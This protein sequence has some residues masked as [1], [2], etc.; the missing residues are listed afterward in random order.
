MFISGAP[1]ALKSVLERQNPS[2]LT[3]AIQIAVQMEQ[4]WIKIK[5]AKQRIQEL[6]EMEDHEMEHRQRLEPQSIQQENQRRAKTG[7]QPFKPSLK[8]SAK[9]VPPKEETKNAQKETLLE[10]IQLP[11]AQLQGGASAKTAPKSASISE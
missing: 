2:S 5:L 11:V 9:T 7:C 1:G 3:E 10:H 4:K 6:A 8:F